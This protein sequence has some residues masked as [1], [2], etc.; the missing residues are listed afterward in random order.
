MKRTQKQIDAM[1]RVAAWL[2]DGA[3]HVELKNGSVL[4]G[5]EY[6]SW[7]RDVAE[8]NNTGACGTV[9]C[10]AGAAVQFENPLIRVRQGD[11][12]WTDMGRDGKV[13]PVEKE[14]RELLGLTEDEAEYLF[15]PFDLSG[16]DIEAM[17]GDVPMLDD[18]DDDDDW[19]TPLANLR[20]AKPE[21]IARVL[22][23]FNETGTINWELVNAEHDE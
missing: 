6:Q 13:V 3:P 11:N 14:A 19:D 1:E 5:F 15:Y 23:H 21:Q 20:H 10:I 22:R 8:D 7:V 18:A 17:V 4:E 9:A 16:Y 12:P 2:A